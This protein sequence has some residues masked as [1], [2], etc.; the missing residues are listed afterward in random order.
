MHGIYVWQPRQNLAVIRTR[1]RFLVDTED[2]V[3][4]ENHTISSG[5]PALLAAYSAAMQDIALSNCPKV[6]TVLLNT[7]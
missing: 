6:E 4:M 7:S 2:I 5:S 3:K 1:V